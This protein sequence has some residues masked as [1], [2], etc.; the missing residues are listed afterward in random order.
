MGMNPDTNKTYLT[1]LLLC[2]LET[3]TAW[4]ECVTTLCLVST[5][6][7]NIIRGNFTLENRVWDCIFHHL[8]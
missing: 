3:T 4:Y 5:H 8:Q 2:C 7:A 1:Q 6:Y